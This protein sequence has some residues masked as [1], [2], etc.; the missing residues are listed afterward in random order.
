MMR[1]GGFSA[2]S[3][4]GVPLLG[5]VCHLQLLLCW[6]FQL[7]LGYLCI[8]WQRFGILLHGL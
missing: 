4:L 5:Q 2:I 6:E 7:E 3:K 1:Q 8:C